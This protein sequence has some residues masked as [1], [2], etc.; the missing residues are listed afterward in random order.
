[1]LLIM[2]ELILIAGAQKDLRG[3]ACEDPRA[4]AY[5]LQYVDAKRAEH[6]EAYESL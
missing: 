3:K 2:A 5:L 4:E 6:N 1:M